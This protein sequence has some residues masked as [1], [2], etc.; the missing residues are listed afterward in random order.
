MRYLDATGNRFALVDGIADDTPDDP[1]RLAR[2]LCGPGD[3]LHGLLLLTGPSPAAVQADVRMQVWNADGSRP[4]ACGNGLRCI[5][6]AATETSSGGA[7]GATGS[8]GRGPRLWIA[9]R[10]SEG[11]R[12]TDS[13]R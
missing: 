10:T 11:L 9:S 7:W 13:P 6:R 12:E 1:A 5:A 8:S 4:E 2:E 3:E